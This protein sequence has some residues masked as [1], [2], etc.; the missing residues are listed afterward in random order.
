[1]ALTDTLATAEHPPL[2]VTVTVYSAG[3]QM[4]NGISGS[5]TGGGTLGI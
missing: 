5:P 3:S 1:M 2:P 4:A